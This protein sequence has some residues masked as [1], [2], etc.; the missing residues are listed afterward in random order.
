VVRLALG[1]TAS[2]A[3]YSFGSTNVTIPAGAKSVRATLCAVVDEVDDGEESVAVSIVPQRGYLV[4][5]A[6]ARVRL[7]DTHPEA[8]DPI[9]GEERT[10]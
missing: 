8:E 1:G 6:A 3:D 7:S 9:S 2:G 5:G 10:Q 4:G